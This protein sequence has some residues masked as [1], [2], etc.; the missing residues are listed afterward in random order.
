VSED[1]LGIIIQC[2]HVI[3]LPC[4]RGTFVANRNDHIMTPSL[5]MYGEFAED[6][7]EVLDKYVKPG[8]TVIDVGANIGVH[9]VALSDMV[10]RNG[11]VLSFE[12]VLCTYNLLCA[13][14]AFS[15]NQNV[16]AHRAMVGD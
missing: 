6:E 9:S 2:A 13:N 7:L 16:I 8:M 15:G 11:L 3:I 5:A 4:K 14:L 10:G 1:N 12:P